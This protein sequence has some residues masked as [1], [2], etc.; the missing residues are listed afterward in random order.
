MRY[1]E[2]RSELT[3]DPRTGATRPTR[4][5]YFDGGRNTTR[6][7]GCGGVADRVSET[8]TGGFVDWYRPV[9][10][11]RKDRMNRGGGPT[12]WRRIDGPTRRFGVRD[13]DRPEVIRRYR[14]SPRWYEGWN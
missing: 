4:L 9:S 2:C 13:Y 3:T 7:P 11:G 8:T 5:G 14:G 6:C 1:Y 12:R 10:A